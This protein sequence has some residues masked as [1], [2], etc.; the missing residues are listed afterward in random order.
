M[1]D[2]FDGMWQEREELLNIEEKN[3]PFCTCEDYGE[4]DCPIH[5]QKDLDII[6]NQDVEKLSKPNKKI[7]NKR[8]TTAKEKG[9]DGI[10][11][12]DS[13]KR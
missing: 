6:P 12:L 5:T 13:F 9:M 1:V 3:D 7:H 11:S 2:D 10:Q 4:D 8:K